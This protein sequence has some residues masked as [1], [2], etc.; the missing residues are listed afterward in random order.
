MSTFRDKSESR[1]GQ[2]IHDEYVKNKPKEAERERSEREAKQRREA[3]EE[4]RRKEE[5]KERRIQKQEEWNRVVAKAKKTKS[6]YLDNLRGT[7]KCTELQL[8]VGNYSTSR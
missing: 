6:I 7:N 1:V 8:P 3:E 5:L 4:R 2:K